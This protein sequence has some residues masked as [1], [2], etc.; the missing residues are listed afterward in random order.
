VADSPGA[1]ILAEFGGVVDAAECAVKI[2]EALK[3]KNAEPPEN[4]RMEFRNGVNLGDSRRE[5]DSTYSGP[6]AVMNGPAVS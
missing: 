1:D 6:R 2:Q 3:A 5:A 4:R